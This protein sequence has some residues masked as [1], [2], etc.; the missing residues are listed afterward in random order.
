VSIDPSSS[1]R[2][3]LVIAIKYNING[4]KLVGMLEDKDRTTL[5]LVLNPSANGGNFTVELPRNVKDSEGASNAD[6][7]IK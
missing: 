5:A 2:T 3:E 4:G 1:K 7:N 6:T